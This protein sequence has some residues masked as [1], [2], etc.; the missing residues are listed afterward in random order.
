MTGERI[1]NCPKR[2]HVRFVQCSFM[3]QICQITDLSLFE[4]TVRSLRF[5]LVKTLGILN[6][7]NPIYSSVHLYNCEIISRS[8]VLK[9]NFLG[10]MLWNICDIEHVN[11]DKVFWY[12]YVENRYLW[13]Y[14]LSYNKAKFFKCLFVV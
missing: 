9:V 14:N 10:H 8:L 11:K 1:W 12:T 13:T 6:L 2:M 7:L 4:Q 3:M 5:C